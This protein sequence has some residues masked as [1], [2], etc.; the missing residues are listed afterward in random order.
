MKQLLGKIRLYT[1]DGANHVAIPEGQSTNAESQVQFIVHAMTDT[2]VKF[3]FDIRTGSA[4]HCK[5]G[6]RVVA[7]YSNGLWYSGRIHGVTNSGS[8]TIEPDDGLKSSNRDGWSNVPCSRVLKT[9]DD[10]SRKK[11]CWRAQRHGI[12][13]AFKT[14][15]CQ[16]FVQPAASESLGL[17]IWF[18]DEEK[19][20]W[21]PGDLSTF[22]SEICPQAFSLSPGRHV[23][24]VS[25]GQGSH[26]RRVTFTDGSTDAGFLYYPQRKTE[27]FGNW[28]DKGSM[29]FR[30]AMKFV[31][32]EE[33]PYVV[34]DGN[35]EPQGLCKVGDRIV[36]AYTNSLWYSGRVR[37]ISSSS[38]C[39]VE[40]DDGLNDGNRAGW[41]SVSCNRVL[42]S[43]DNGSHKK[44]CWRKQK[45]AIPKTFAVQK[46]DA[47][48]FEEAPP[49]G[50]CKVNDRIVAAYSNGLWYSGKIHSIS[51]H[52]RCTIE[53]D[54]GLK[55]SNR[56]GWSN[57]PCNRVLKSSDDGSK[58]KWCWRSQ[59]NAIPSDFV[60][61]ACAGFQVAGGSVAST[62]SS[63]EASWLELIVEVAKDTSMK[64]KAFL[65]TPDQNSDSFFIW[66]D[67][68]E[69]YAWNCGVHQSWTWVECPKQFSLSA[70]RHVLC[71]GGRESGAQIGQVAL[72][73]N[74]AGFV[75]YKVDSRR[76]VRRLGSAENAFKRFDADGSGMVSLD[77]MTVVLQSLMP[78]LN[79]ENVKALFDAADCNKDGHVDYQEFI[80]WM[81]ESETPIL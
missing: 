43:S 15:A 6:D 73:G 57:V 11:W 20:S 22:T 69:Q 61:V 12:P 54:D 39:T 71:V 77:E 26:L 37:S 75:D 46:C 70:G 8:C 4:C 35:S 33:Q 40:P 64:L 58:K 72:V 2:T 9:N 29:K 24:H 7:A 36:A 38:T 47:F 63:G 19:H 59:R 13:N 17:H 31:E 34:F 41:S 1:E 65:K 42:K 78:G 81:T 45:H 30:G 5:V 50:I 51:N 21:N 60:T 52:G 49:D 44:W 48:A 74:H 53:P 14:E 79:S 10:G 62:A 16:G 68:G 32:D 80:A 25:L 76:I 66:F 67:K 55:S 23:L 27:N 18:D 28:K 3:R 56:A